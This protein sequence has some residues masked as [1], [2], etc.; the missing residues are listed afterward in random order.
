MFLGASAI[1]NTPNIDLTLFMDFAMVDFC[2]TK[3]SFY[4]NINE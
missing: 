2:S 1:V 4:E 3:L